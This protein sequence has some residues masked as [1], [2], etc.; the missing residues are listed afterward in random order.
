MRQNS[1]TPQFLQVSRL[2]DGDNMNQNELSFSNLTYLE[3]IY[4]LYGHTGCVHPVDLA[5][6]LQVSK[7]SVTRA[8]RLLTEEGLIRKNSCGEILATQKGASIA[9]KLCEK[10]KTLRA[11]FEKTIGPISKFSCR[12]AIRLSYSM[13]DEIVHAIQTY[14]AQSVDSDVPAVICK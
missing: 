1:I 10:C 11:L 8:L 5:N 14:L 13:S 2:R 9:K 4:R 3:A 7:P 6:D 12:E